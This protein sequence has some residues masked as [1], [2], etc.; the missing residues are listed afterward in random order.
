MSL[1]RISRAIKYGFALR[2]ATRYTIRENVFKDRN[3]QIAGKEEDLLVMLI[4]SI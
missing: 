3:Y 1:F 2:N 4:N